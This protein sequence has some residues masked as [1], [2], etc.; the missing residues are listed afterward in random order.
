M[1]LLSLYVECVY[2]GIKQQKTLLF[3]SLELVIF[4]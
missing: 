4:L 3:G 1:A 2:Y